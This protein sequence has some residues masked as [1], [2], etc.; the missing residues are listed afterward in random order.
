MHNDAV[1]AVAG[2]AGL[3][4]PFWI[5]FFD[6]VF[7]FLIAALGF[8]VLVETVWNKALEIRLKRAALKDIEEAEHGETPQK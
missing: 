6:P 4:A 8:V 7:Q 5:H 1:T 2:G 3:T